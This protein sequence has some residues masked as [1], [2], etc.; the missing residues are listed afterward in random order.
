M[1]SLTPPPQYSFHK[2]E[3]LTVPDIG[4]AVFLVFPARLPGVH[5]ADMGISNYVLHPPSAK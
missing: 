2:Y 3:L 4:F 5:I 1:K